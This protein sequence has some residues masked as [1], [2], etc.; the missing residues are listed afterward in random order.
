MRTFRRTKV[1]RRAFRA[2]L[3]LVLSHPAAD[4]LRAPPRP[5]ANRQDVRIL[6]THLFFYADFLSVANLVF[7]PALCNFTDFFIK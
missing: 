6:R 3:R 7:L 5:N 4:A 2:P 1:R